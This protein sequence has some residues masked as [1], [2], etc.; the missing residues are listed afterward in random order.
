MGLSGESDG[1]EWNFKYPP[2][3]AFELWQIQKK[4]T[5]MRKLHLDMWEATTSL[6]GTGRPVDAILS[7]VAASVAPPHGMN[8]YGCV[9]EKIVIQNLTSYRDADYTM[10]WK[11]LDYP[12]CVFPVS[13]FDPLLDKKVERS[14]FLSEKDEF[15]Y[16]T[17]GCYATL[18][19]TM[20]YFFDSLD[21][22]TLLTD[23][24][25][26]LQLVGRTLEDEAVIGMTE[27]VDAALKA[28]A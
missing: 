18:Q 5:D 21:D 8:R 12:A 11:G 15:T 4:R 28:Q 7:P 3:S 25:V 19:Q 26:S 13:K 23:A 2:M 22:P 10:V 24:P 27:I 20:T 17:C 16:K 14:T 9:I 6:T 1:I